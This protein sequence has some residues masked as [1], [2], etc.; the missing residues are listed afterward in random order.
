MNAVAPSRDRL[1]CRATDLARDEELALNDATFLR[2][3]SRSATPVKVETP[4][5]GQGLVLGMSLG[6]EHWRDI[7]AGKAAHRHHFQRNSLYLRDFEIAYRAELGGQFDFLL[8]EIPWE[9]FLPQDETR[10][11]VMPRR[12]D[13]ETGTTDPT[14]THLLSAIQPMLS[15]QQPR[16]QLFI[17]QV[18]EAL[19]T[20]LRH[21]YARTCLP[22]RPRE[23][24]PSPL[25]RQ[26]LEI[27]RTSLDGNV[28]LDDIARRCNVSRSHFYQVF[29]QELGCTPHEWLV[30]TRLEQA[31]ALLRRPGLSLADIAA[32]CGFADQ[33]H[34]TRAFGRRFGLSP[35][36]WRA[37]HGAAS[38]REPASG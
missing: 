30:R 19:V 24:R 28:S 9:R 3:T 18:A 8:V 15:G 11:R 37:E 16:D 29:R 4:P 33:S 26:A 2:K 34:F 14:V 21:R 25:I 36:R 31:R 20:Y 17:D 1:G 27:L 7:R 10:P 35:G 23:H 32:Q 22:E 6:D 5:T 13:F 38:S 12:I